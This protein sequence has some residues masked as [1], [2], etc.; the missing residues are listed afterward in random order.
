MRQHGLARGGSL[1]N[2]IVVGKRIVLN[3]HLR[4]GDEFVR[5]KV[6]DLVGDLHTLGRPIAGH[7]VGRNAGHTLNNELA[8]AIRKACSS[9]RR[10]DGARALTSAAA[11]S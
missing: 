10:R 5:H 11:R 7:V 3:D 4:F 8:L 9:G 1:D 6:L 2:A